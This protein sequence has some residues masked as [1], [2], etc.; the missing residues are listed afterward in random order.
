MPRRFASQ[1]K[2][3]GHIERTSKIIQKMIQIKEFAGLSLFFLI[4]IKIYK[5]TRIAITVRKML[6]GVI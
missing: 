2:D 5:M 4:E 6:V 1:S 3:A